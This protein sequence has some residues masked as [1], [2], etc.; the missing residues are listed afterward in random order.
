MLL[1]HFEEGCLIDEATA[2]ESLCSAPQF[3]VGDVEP[4]VVATYHI[5]KEQPA[6]SNATPGPAALSSSAADMQVLRKS[7]NTGLQRPRSGPKAGSTRGA[8]N[9]GVTNDRL[10]LRC[11]RECT[12]MR[13][14]AT[15]EYYV[16][17]AFVHGKTK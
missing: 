9:V 10:L 16:L 2:L 4:K 13:T 1:L 14:P 15:E 3:K 7:A 12:V 11:P 8:E 5:L 6:A 17:V